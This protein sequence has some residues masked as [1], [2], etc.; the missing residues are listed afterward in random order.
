[1]SCA[2]RSWSLRSKVPTLS[3]KWQF[4]RVLAR[5]LPYDKSNAKTVGYLKLYG[6]MLC[7][8]SVSPLF[9]LSFAETSY[10]DMYRMKLWFI[11]VCSAMLLFPVQLA[12]IESSYSKENCVDILFF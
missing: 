8:G 10:L 3:L 7:I 5:F 1:M 12:L 11:I 4:D 2:L 9:K 6:Q